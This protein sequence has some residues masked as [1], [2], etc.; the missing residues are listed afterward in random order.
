MGN[1]HDFSSILADQ[2][3]VTLHGQLRKLLVLHLLSEDHPRPIFAHYSWLEY[4]GY[5]KQ[6]S[7]PPLASDKNASFC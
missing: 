4:S 1:F 2:D 7:L 5:I 3:D 6:A